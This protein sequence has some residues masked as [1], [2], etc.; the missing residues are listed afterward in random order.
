MQNNFNVSLSWHVRFENYIRGN[1]DNN[2]ESSCIIR[3]IKSRRMRFS[4][5]VAY[6]EEKRNKY[7][8]FVG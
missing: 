8:V 2:L 7:K 3:M 4:E 5:Q 1:P 6:M